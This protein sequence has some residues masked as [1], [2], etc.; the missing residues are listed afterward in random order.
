SEGTHWSQCG[1]FQRHMIVAI[2][3]C[4]S[5]KCEY[6]YLHPKGCR[7]PSC[8]KR[9]GAEVEKIVDT[10]NDQC[11]TCRMARQRAS[12]PYAA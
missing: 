1:H 3:D 4:N 8:V 6:S 10:V 5:S 11:F 12:R 9:Y 2:M 7:D